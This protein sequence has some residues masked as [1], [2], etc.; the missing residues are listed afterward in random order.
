MMTSRGTMLTFFTTVSRSFSSSTRWVGTPC[1]SN[2]PMR[3]L[4]MRLLMAPLPEMVPFLRPLNAVASSLY[5][6]MSFSG[7]PVVY[8]FLALPS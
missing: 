4:L 3:K 7:S 1:F 5:A 6:T 2:I 8:T